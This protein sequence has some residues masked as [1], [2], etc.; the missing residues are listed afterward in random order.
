MAWW[1]SGF[2]GLPGVIQKSPPC[3]LTINACSGE[4]GLEM[5]AGHAPEDGWVHAPQRGLP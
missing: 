1:V 4:D 2:A 3:L 5:V